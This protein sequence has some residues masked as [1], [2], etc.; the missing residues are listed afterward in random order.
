M[1]RETSPTPELVRSALS[2]RGL[3]RSAAVVAGA[4]VAGPLLVGCESS[5][6]K[7]PGTTSS[8]DISKIIPSYQANNLVAPDIP[9]VTGPAGAVSD[10]GFLSF[11]SNPV[12]TVT[13]VPGKGS[14]YTTITPLWGSIPPS[15][16]NGY[17]DAV[18]KAL[19]ATL[20]MQPADGN[21]YGDTTLPPLFAADKLPDW[22][23]IPGWNTQKLNFGQAVE[24][25]FADLT[26]Y[27][28]G[29]KVKDYPNLANVSSGAWACGVWN[30]KLYGIP[31]YP[32]GAVV[33][34]AYFYRAD[35]FD[36]QGIKGE[37]IKT[38][39]DIE[40]LGKQLTN[41]NGGVWAFDDLF[42]T[43]AAYIAQLF[44][45]PNKWGIGSDG[46][47]IHKY[48]HPG[49]VEALNWHAKLVKSGWVHPD[50]IAANNQNGKQRFWSG[51][52]LVCADGTGAWNGDDAKSGTAANPGYRRLAFALQ[53]SDASVKPSIELGNGASM[54]SYLNKKLSADQ[55][56]ECLAIANYLAAPYGSAEWLLV[57]YGIEGQEFT[58]TG[59]NPSLTDKGSKEV[60][61]TFQFLAC[62]PSPT[63]V[64]N[65]FSQVAKDYCAWQGDM[66]KL[67]VKPAFYG[68]NVTE[69]SQYSS[70]GQAVTDAMAD[71]K[72][73]RKPISAYTDAVKTWQDQGGNALR[74]FY[75]GIREKY[76]TGQ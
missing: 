71:V 63:T 28:A 61:T 66:V 52:S 10:P 27:L 75:Q 8:N 42:G 74:D 45:F 24:A 7:G 19:G 60:A 5:G 3:F 2:R 17:Y 57:N 54:F 6:T 70:I 13:S 20:K 35:V 69:P 68:M 55:I 40:A 64:S 9:S 38:T 56:K 62:P 36:K 4:A 76:G 15:S 53:T 44:H 18:N 49:M 67:A 34:G 59:G 48:E 23:Q 37:D 22:I 11:P 14:S 46:K 43:D 47:L 50:A 72:V 73:G 32:S 31:I 21:N 12:K 41:S 65:G 25:K 1:P 30:G 29:D 26:P 51:K 39:A 33:N 16:G 58:M